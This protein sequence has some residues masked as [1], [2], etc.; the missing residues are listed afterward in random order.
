MSETNTSTTDILTPQTEQTRLM[1]E[2]L[3]EAQARAQRQSESTE[4]SLKLRA[5]LLARLRA[6][7]PRGIRPVTLSD[8]R[9]FVFRKAQRAEYMTYK[10]QS[11]QLVVNPAVAANAPTA[12]AQS[13][14]LFPDAAQF[15]ALCESDPD[16]VD[17]IGVMLAGDIGTGV[18]IATGKADP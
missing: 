7:H 4:Q 16:V 8:G 15:A 6:E 1:A 12:L 9:L 5:E 17:E 10:A 14:L 13:L 18:T 2:A 11:L 3:A